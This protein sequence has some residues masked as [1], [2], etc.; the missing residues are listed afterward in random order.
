[1]TYI[2]QGK[3]ER[4]RSSVCSPRALAA[5][6]EFRFPGHPTPS[7]LMLTFLLYNKLLLVL[8]A[9]SSPVHT[10]SRV[11]RPRGQPM[12]RSMTVILKV[13]KNYIY[14]RKILPPCHK[15]SIWGQLTRQFKC[16]VDRFAVGY[17]VSPYAG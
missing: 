13:N 6:A 3:G 4:D 15:H 5:A 17:L 12:S 14:G 10:P 11:E 9:K 1:M 7:A 16:S 2:E 8:W